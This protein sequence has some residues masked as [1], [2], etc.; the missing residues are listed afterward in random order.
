MDG[1]DE[2]VGHYWLQLGRRSKSQLHMFTALLSYIICGLLPPVL[3]GFSFR[4]SNDRE[5]KMMTV[6]AASLVCIALLAL[7]KVH[8]KSRT[9][10][11]FKTLMYYLTIALSCSG[12]S[13]VAGMLITRLLVN[14]GIVDQGGASA[15]PAP[16]GL[17]FPHALGAETSAWASF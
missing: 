8:V 5:N 14:F 12:L 10:T 15:T 7:G 13:Y 6:A 2:Q 3:Y 17:L 16:P 11:Y 9:R 4:E 1:E